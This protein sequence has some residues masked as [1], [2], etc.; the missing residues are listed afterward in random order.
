MLPTNDEENQELIRLLDWF[1]IHTIHLRTSDVLAEGQWLD[2]ATGKQIAYS[3]WKP[4][5]P[6]NWQGTEHYAVL[7][8]DRVWNDIKWDYQ[9]IP[10]CQKVHT[11]GMTKN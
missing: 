3:D 8:G 4:G 6:D 9:A 5:Q 2:L 10:L 7:N 11:P 1:E